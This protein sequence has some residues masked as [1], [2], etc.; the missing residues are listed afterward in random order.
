MPTPVR[1]SV[2]APR[3]EPAPVYQPPPRRRRAVFGLAAEAAAQ[4]EA[5]QGGRPGT[6]GSSRQPARVGSPASRAGAPVVRHGT[7]PCG[8]P[9]STACVAG[10]GRPVCGEHLLNRAS[11]LGWS[12]PYRS[13]REHTAYLRAFWANAAPLCSWCREASATAALAAMAPVAPLPVGALE[14]LA[15]LL[16]HPHD[17]PRDAWDQTVRQHGGQ[18]AVLRLLAP[19]VCDRKLSQEFEGRKKGDFLAG[20]SV[21]GCSGRQ[22]TY[23]VLDRSGA[24]WTVRPLESVLVRKRRA[25]AWEA[26]A[27]ERVAQLLPRIVE[28]A[29]I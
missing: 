16:R 4:A 10:C 11:R 24:V 1:R 9:A 18:A 22:T 29:A 6:A 23:E 8:L 28:L 13:E 27:G 20:V 21:G 15:F 12:D 17:Y 2:P 3:P 25:W 26:T 7:C 14:C 19:R 5:R